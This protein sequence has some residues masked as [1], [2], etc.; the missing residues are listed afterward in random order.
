M[1]SHNSLGA[2]YF[3]E[4]FLLFSACL[5]N[6]PIAME[7][8]EENITLALNS[9]TCLNS[10]DLGGVVF[11]PKEW[12]SQNESQVYYISSF[13]WSSHIWKLLKSSSL[14][15]LSLPPPPFSPSYTLHI[16]NTHTHTHLKV[17]TKTKTKN[18]YQ[19]L[20]STIFYFSVLLKLSYHFLSKS[21]QP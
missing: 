11:I 9:L 1:D 13:L 10:G 19:P 4:T 8:V 7:T 21:E 15:S 12:K 5:I 6:L 3:L 18:W 17:K 14:F 20:K 16:H 2:C